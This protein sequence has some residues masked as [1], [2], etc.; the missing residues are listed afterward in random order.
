M[1]I[2]SN[3]PWAVWLL[4]PVYSYLSKTATGLYGKDNAIVTTSACNS[5]A[6]PF[7]WDLATCSVSGLQ[8]SNLIRSGPGQGIMTVYWNNPP[9]VSL[10][11]ILDFF[12][13]YRLKQYSGQP[14]IYFA[15]KNTML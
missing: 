14:L 9:S 15:P 2:L 10:L 4:S 11:L 8:P 12:H 1:Q 3:P 5:V 7:S 6:G 13:W